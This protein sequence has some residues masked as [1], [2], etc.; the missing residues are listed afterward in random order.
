[1][2]KRASRR[3]TGRRV[4][5]RMERLEMRVCVVRRGQ[6]RRFPDASR[7]RASV[8]QTATVQR[9]RSSAAS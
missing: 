6:R 7:Y 8:D 5:E 9:A 4:S 3:S 2:Q 1:M